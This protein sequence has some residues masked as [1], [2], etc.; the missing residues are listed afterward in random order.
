MLN[1]VFDAIDKN[2]DGQIDFT[3]AVLSNRILY[4]RN[5]IKQIALLSESDDF[6]EKSNCNEKQV[7]MII[8]TFFDSIYLRSDS[9]RNLMRTILKKI[10]LI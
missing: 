2:Q 8:E 6:I 10:L 3:E 9:K 4:D 1:L 7:E 5:Q